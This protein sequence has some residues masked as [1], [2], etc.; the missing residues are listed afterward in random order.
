MCNSLSQRCAAYRVVLSAYIAVYMPQLASS[1]AC[2]ELWG[3]GQQQKNSQMVTSLAGVT[4]SAAFVEAT[5]NPTACTSSWMFQALSQSFVGAAG[6]CHSPGQGEE[7][8][9][10]TRLV[11]S[12]AGKVRPARQLSTGDVWPD[13]PEKSSRKLLYKQPVQ[14]KSGWRENSSYKTARPLVVVQKHPSLQLSVL[15]RH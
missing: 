9:Q 10:G 7:Q 6:A 5:L 13:I 4:L 2:M 1:H 3:L 14:G 11:I 15:M 12:A 8:C